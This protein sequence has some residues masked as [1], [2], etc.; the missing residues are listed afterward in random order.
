MARRIVTAR[1]SPALIVAVVALVAAV[2][3]TAIAGP[4]A[5]TSAIS[6][7]KVKKIANKQINKRLPLTGADIDYGIHKVR[8]LSGDGD[9]G[10]TATCP[11]G[12]IAIG[13]GSDSFDPADTGAVQ[14]NSP[15]PSI[16]E[17]ATGWQVL[18][19]SGANAGDI[20]VFAICMPD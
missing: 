3:G 9:F 17:P 13:G 14:T 8:V 19:E 4:G 5:S 18:Y 6:K 1:P 20:A 2:A 10:E 12:E 16:G 15:T 11:D 7:S